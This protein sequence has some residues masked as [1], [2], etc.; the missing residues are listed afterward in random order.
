VLRLQADY[1]V[2]IENGWLTLTMWWLCD[3]VGRSDRGT[4]F[5]RPV[6]LHM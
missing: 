4:G 1:D 3:L 2:L 6:L 5:Y